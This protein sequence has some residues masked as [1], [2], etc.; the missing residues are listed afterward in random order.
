MTKG[1]VKRLACCRV[2]PVSG[3]VIHEKTPIRPIP[4]RFQALSLRLLDLHS[5]QR[6]ATHKQ[7]ANKQNG[8]LFAFR[9]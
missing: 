4:R 6:F 7:A 2:A 9:P 5:S 1:R 3:W 8:R